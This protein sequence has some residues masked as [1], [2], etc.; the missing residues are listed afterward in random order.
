MIRTTAGSRMTTASVAGRTVLAVM[1]LAAVSLL[2]ACGTNMASASATFKPNHE[3]QHVQ[4]PVVSSTASLEIDG[5]VT[6]LRLSRSVPIVQVRID[7]A[8]PFD[9]VL[10]T[11][12]GLCIVS[13]RLVKRLGDTAR[14]RLSRSNGTVTDVHGRSV[15]VPHELRG[16][17]WTLGPDAGPDL[18]SVSAAVLPLDHVRAAFGESIEGILGLPA[19]AGLALSIDYARG[20]LRVGRELPAELAAVQPESRI[21][22]ASIG[23]R[24]LRVPVLWRGQSFDFAVDTAS[25]LGI[26]VS[27]SLVWR[28]AFAHP[29]RRAVGARGLTG[30]GEDEIIGRLYDDMTLAG[31][32]LHRPIV[33]SGSDNRIG[34]GL[35]RHFILHIDT[36]RQRLVFE[37]YGQ[38]TRLDF[39]PV[40][41][42]WPDFD[43]RPTAAGLLVISIDA[44]A[45]DKLSPLHVG[46]LIV[47]AG[48]RPVGQL[49]PTAWAALLGRDEPV[50]LT[51]RRGDRLVAVVLP[52]YAMIP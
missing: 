51:V 14:P 46:D 15:D 9:M 36:R 22:A 4:S 11:G 5:Q 12:A 23:P 28:M 13:P 26:E 16:H 8:G 52:V 7:G 6:T 37:P 50:S 43:V 49:S 30:G 1:L 48:G 47:R 34:T 19:F 25:T 20:Q 40:R 31:I 29:P 41:R 27:R 45:V 21:V 42:V 18:G 44:G 10:D 33:R 32:A 2:A 24:G 3:R 38:R 39:A 17:R 35:L